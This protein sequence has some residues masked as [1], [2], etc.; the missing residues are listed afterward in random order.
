VNPAFRTLYEQFYRENLSKQRNRIKAV[1]KKKWIPGDLEL[2]KTI[3]RYWYLGDGSINS[4]SNHRVSQV[5]RMSTEDL[6]VSQLRSVVLPQLHTRWGI[7]ASLMKDKRIRIKNYGY[8]LVIPAWDAEVLLGLIGPSPVKSYRYKFKVVAR[9]RVRLNFVAEKVLLKYWG[10]IPRTL[11]VR[12]VGGS[13]T[14]ARYRA[15]IAFRNQGKAF[16]SYPNRP[17][18]FRPR[19]TNGEVR[20]DPLVRLLCWQERMRMNARSFSSVHNP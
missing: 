6:P 16:P 11:L 9:R 18:K 4:K 20:R 2:T 8:Y 3:L 15:R 13:Y 5:V 10:K 1:N 14:G 17:E 7:K 12:L 19:Y